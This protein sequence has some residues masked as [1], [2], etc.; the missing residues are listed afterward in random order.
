MAPPRERMPSRK[1]DS[2]SGQEAILNGLFYFSGI[3][4]GANT[5]D[6]WVT[7]ENHGRHA[8]RNDLDEVDSSVACTALTA[9][10]CFQRWSIQARTLRRRSWARTEP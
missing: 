1:Q 5:G 4:N 10:C 7:D 3:A 6:L 9:E 2:S 8:H